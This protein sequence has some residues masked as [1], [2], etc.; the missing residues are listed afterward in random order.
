[1]NRRMKV[2]VSVVFRNPSCKYEKYVS[3]SIYP[4]TAWLQASNVSV[5]KSLFSTVESQLNATRLRGGWWKISEGLQV[6]E[7]DFNMFAE[8]QPVIILTQPSDRST[9]LGLVMRCHSDFFH[10]SI[11]CTCSHLPNRNLKR[12]GRNSCWRIHYVPQWRFTCLE[13]T[14]MR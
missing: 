2:G 1:M 14:W 10:D 3:D 5:W 8:L 12:K 6:P 9:K 4:F 7:L 13:N 11:S